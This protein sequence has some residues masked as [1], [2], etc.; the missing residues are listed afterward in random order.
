M[1]KSI[2]LKNFQSHADSFLE[3]VPGINIITGQS[4]HG[5]TSIMRALGWVVNNRPQGIAFKST[6]STKKETCKVS[7]IINDKEIIREKNDSVNKYQIGISEFDTIGNDVPEEIIS[8][9]NI[10]DINFST[11]FEK[12]FLLTDSAGEVG[13]TINKIVNLDII[14]GLTSN[15]T[16]KINSTNKELEIRKQDLEKL[17]ISL[18]KFRDFEIIEILVTKLSELDKQKE[19]ISETLPY[20]NHIINQ[21]QE[22]DKIIIATEN[23]YA[24][25]ENQVKQLETDWVIYNANKLIIDDLYEL[26]EKIQR[27]DKI[28]GESEQITQTEEQVKVFETSLVSFISIYETV[29]KMESILQEWNSYIIKIKRI[30]KSIEKEEAEFEKILKDFGCPLCGRSL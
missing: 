28:I 16:T 19:E 29:G 2:H 8:A 26:I 23:K 11:Q 7:L 1:I 25:I 3:F 22:Y 4:N 12:H 20:L 27:E 10:N 13:R 6:F 24:D 9:I 30:E 21:I 17:N 15:L 14:D 18:E 5:K